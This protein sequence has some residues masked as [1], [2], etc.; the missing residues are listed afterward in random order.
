MLIEMTK[1][2]TTASL[3]DVFRLVH[4]RIIPSIIFLSLLINTPIYS[5]PVEKYGKLLDTFLEQLHIE[6]YWVA[7]K[8][9]NWKTGVPVVPEVELPNDR[10]FCSAFV[11]AVCLRLGIYIPRPPQYSLEFLAMTQNIWLKKHG[12]EEGWFYVESGMDA[13]ELANMGF[14][15]VASYRQEPPG[16]RGH[17]AIVR[18]STKSSQLIAQEGPD[19]IQA[20]KINYSLTSISIGF[21][22]FNHAFK[23]NQICYFAHY[24]PHDILEKKR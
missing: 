23:N 11:A 18:P 7:G 19:I 8:K 15:V 12:Y 5:G 21:Q 2:K 14:L 9:I 20:G 24:I 22:S 10:S 6:Q 16:K 3:P 13:Q 17:I 1:N 4:S